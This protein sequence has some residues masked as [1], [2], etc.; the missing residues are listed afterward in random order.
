MLNSRVIAVLFSAFLMLNIFSVI[1]LDNSAAPPD[2]NQT[3]DQTFDDIWYSAAA[4]KIYR[5]YENLTTKGVHINSSGAMDWINITCNNTVNNFEV[6]QNGY[7][8]ITNST[9]D[10]IGNFIIRGHVRLINSTLVMN[11]SYNGEFKLE[12]TSTGNFTAINST[13]TAYDQTTL[14]NG[15][16]DFK[17]WGDHY[18][19]TVLKNG[20]MTLIDCN[21]SHAWG[22]IDLTSRYGGG[23]RILS[24]DVLIFNCTISQC[25]VAGVFV[26]GDVSPEI[27]NC[28]IENNTFS[29]VYTIYRAKP[30]IDGNLIRNSPSWA[31][32]GANFYMESEPIFSN[33]TVEN[34]SIDGIVIERYSNVTIENN[35]IRNCSR[36]GIIVWGAPYAISPMI[37][38]NH[39]HNTSYGI[40]LI[41]FYV[42]GATIVLGSVS[43]NVS[44][45]IIEL[46]NVSGMLLNNQAASAG[47]TA[48][49]NTSIYNNSII[50]NEHGLFMVYSDPAVIENNLTNNNM[51]GLYI[52]D[53]ST[54][55]VSY[56][57]IFYNRESG[58][59][60]NES[61]APVIFNNTIF[62]ND[63]HGILTIDA[64]P[65]ITS[66]NITT[67]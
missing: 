41:P 22:N 1:T 25:E 40:Y 60:I 58:I 10:L 7:F 11:S 30:I 56:N 19:F 65:T 47:F 14:H 59:I 51:S 36:V 63:A 28:T 64:Q 32:F 43:G 26:Y 24:S 42:V 12:V 50:H 35:I 23:I 44:N 13:I 38:N 52:L 16:N 18:N 46:N 39:I 33:N 17:T 4:Q 45:N 27:R 8:N 3:F 5:S 61:S 6:D 15:A 29:Q 62:N 53:H 57:D 31:G 9:I 21:V 20:K 66:N 54:P 67:N 34:I 55:S 2:N 37:N 49:I 48:S